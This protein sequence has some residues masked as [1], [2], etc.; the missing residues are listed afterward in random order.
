LERLWTWGG[1]LRWLIAT[2]RCCGAITLV[3]LYVAS[4]GLPSAALAVTSTR[5]LAHCRIN[6]Q[7]DS[8]DACLK[9]GTADHKHGISYNRGNPPEGVDA[10]LKCHVGAYCGISC[11]VAIMSDPAAAIVRFAHASFLLRRL[12]ESR[13]GCEPERINRPPKPSLSL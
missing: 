8:L 11:S 6:I 10:K 13:D 7:Y 4:V 12:D 2:L 1:M 3:V 9:D 5:G